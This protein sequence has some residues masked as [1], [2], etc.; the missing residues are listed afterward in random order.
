MKR[1]FIKFSI[2]VFIFICFYIYNLSFVQADEKPT[3]LKTQSVLIVL[4]DNPYNGSDVTWNALR[5][6]DKINKTGTKVRMFIVNDA[7]DLARDATKKPDFYEFDLVQMLKDLMNQGV[8]I[9]VCSSCMARCGVNKNMPYFSK[10][11][12]GHMSDYTKW[13]LSSDKIISF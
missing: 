7:V 2:P 1:I 11:I 4:N 13:V 8:S 3:K 12:E 5:L 10:N 9:K 6:A